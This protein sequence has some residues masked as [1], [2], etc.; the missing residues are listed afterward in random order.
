MKANG[1]TINSGNLLNYGII[2]A[3]SNG[4][5]FIGYSSGNQHVKNGEMIN[6]GII[7]AEN[8]QVF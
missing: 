4:Q 2:N 7:K 1:G 8:G 3:K 5:Y 6:Y